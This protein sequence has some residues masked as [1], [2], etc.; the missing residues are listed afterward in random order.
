MHVSSASMI[1]ETLTVCFHAE[2]LGIVSDEGDCLSAF[3]IAR[4]LYNVY[5]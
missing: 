1:I 2:H 5:S 4:G 3:D